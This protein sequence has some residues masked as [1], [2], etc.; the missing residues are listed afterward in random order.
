MARLLTLLAIVVRILGC[1]DGVGVEATIFLTS[2][3]STG[4]LTTIHLITRRYHLSRCQS[5]LS[6]YLGSLDGRRQNLTLASMNFPQQVCACKLP[7]SQRD[8]F[9]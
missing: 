1:S 2:T 8:E 7:R 9:E 3:S 6:A 5:R 4:A